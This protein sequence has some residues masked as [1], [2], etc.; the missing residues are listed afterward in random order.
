MFSIL[1]LAAIALAALVL[2]PNAARNSPLSPAF[3]PAWFF[4][5]EALQG[6]TRHFRRT[7]GST[8]K[9][10]KERRTVGKCSEDGADEEDPPSGRIRPK[11]LNCTAFP[12]NLPASAAGVLP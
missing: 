8:Y 2:T 6:L 5:V 1:A 4:R 10:G 7:S 3:F 9:D 11:R 12:A